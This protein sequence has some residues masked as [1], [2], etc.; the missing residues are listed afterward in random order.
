MAVAFC[1]IDLQAFEHRTPN[2]K[3]Q[4]SNAAARWRLRSTVVPHRQLRFDFETASKTGAYR[5]A[6]K[7]RSPITYDRFQ[8]VAVLQSELPRVV[9]AGRLTG[10]FR[11]W[12]WVEPARLLTPRG[13]NKRGPGELSIEKHRRI[14]FAG[15]V[16]LGAILW[17][18]LVTSPEKSEEE[19]KPIQIQIEDVFSRT[20]TW[21]DRAI[22]AD[23]E[24]RE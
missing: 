17:Q 14:C 3:R 22:G 11:S 13:N 20:A 19:V 18:V 1:G 21:I 24:K 7:R 12:G 10:W 23:Q 2:T 4:A 5:I 15:P 6:T 16:D 8:E 9:R